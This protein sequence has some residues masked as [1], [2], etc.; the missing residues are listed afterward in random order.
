M[1]DSLSFEGRLS[2][3]AETSQNAR[4]VFLSILLSCVFIIL[5]VVST[6]DAALLAN[7]SLAVLPDLATNIPATSFFWVAPILL[8]CLYVYLHLHMAG[9][10]ETL[11][12]LPAVFPD[13][14]PL[15]KRAYP[16]IATNLLRL[17]GGW[18]GRRFE[19]MV[20]IGLL[21]GTVPLT[22]LVIW[23]RYLPFRDWPMSG[24]H[25]ALIVACFWGAIRLF[26]QT[27][28]MMCGGDLSIRHRRGLLCGLGALLVATTLAVGLF[29]IVFD[30]NPRRTP[31]FVIDV[32]GADLSHAVLRRKDLRY[33]AGRESKLT[34][35]DLRDADLGRADFQRSAFVGAD[36]ESADFSAY[37]SQLRRFPECLPEE[38]EQR[39]ADMEDADFRGAYLGRTD[40]RSRLLTRANFAGANLQ[41]ADLRDADLTGA[42]FERAI[43]GCYASQ[44]KELEPQIECA[45]LRGALLQRAHFAAADLRRAEGLTQA[46][47]DGAC[48]D[49]ATLLPDGL[50]LTGCAEAA[51]EAAEEP[52]PAERRPL[53]AMNAT[54]DPGDGL[55]TN[56]SGR[57]LI[58]KRPLHPCVVLLRRARDHD[59]LAAS[60]LIG[61]SEVG[62][63]LEAENAAEGEKPPL[64][65]AHRMERHRRPG[66]RQRRSYVGMQVKAQLESTPGTAFKSILAAQVGAGLAEIETAPV[67]DAEAPSIAV[68]SCVQPRCSFRLVPRRRDPHRQ[69]TEPADIERVGVLDGERRMSRGRSKRRSPAIAVAAERATIDDEPLAAV[70]HLESERR[71]MSVGGRRA[72]IDDDQRA[73]RRQP[74][75]ADLGGAGPGRRRDLARRQQGI[76]Q[77]PVAFLRAV[78][79]REPAVA[80]SERA[81]HRRHP[82]DGAGERAGQRLARI[83]QRRADIEELTEDLRVQRRVALHVPAVGQDLQR[84]LA[85]QPA[86]RR[87]QRHGSQAEGGGDLAARHGE[88]IGRA[89]QCTR[90]PSQMARLPTRQLEESDPLVAIRAGK[91]KIAGGKPARQPLP[92]GRR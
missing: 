22:L 71:S 84:D 53:A 2:Y 69:R 23:L 64:D 46:Q 47:L 73:A 13:G 5:T 92:D 44:K 8:L 10:G 72:D 86:Q 77:R 18:R 89:T 20:A 33:A 32:R 88:G 42:N 28:T 67:R 59:L 52:Q 3:V 14:T 83:V 16:W 68:V 50:R 80:V 34:G 90:D 1:P 25:V 75:E 4:P 60:R 11:S 76:G 82:L 6:P 57:T 15:D 37:G 61:A 66:F 40:L 55:S 19:E 26:E 63:L 56:P 31:S 21:W 30:L 12:E 27:A 70:A 29:P 54:P 9:I 17:R 79:Q 7:A 58:A 78:K 85:F 35:A 91:Q 39:D 74:L 36:L 49:Q 51:H 62:A 38:G 24:L 43:V 65:T 41:G 81:Q 87:R 48:G 45:D